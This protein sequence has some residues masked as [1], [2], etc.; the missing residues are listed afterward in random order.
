M[1][2]S[3]GTT[4]KPK[5]ILYSY[6]NIFNLAKGISHDFNFSKNDKHLIILPLGHT[7]SLNYN[8]L[9]SLYCGS[10]LY[11]SKGFSNVGKIF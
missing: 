6:S 4:G 5:G 7:A 2:N 11:I 9:P 1:Y 8:L 10:T 3:S